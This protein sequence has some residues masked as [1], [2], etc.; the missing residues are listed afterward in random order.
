M[1]IENKKDKQSQEKQVAELRNERY[2][3]MLDDLQTKQDAFYNL[4]IENNRKM[5]E[6]YDS[7]IK[8]LLEAIRQPHILSQE[9]NARMTKID[10]EIDAYLERTLNTCNATRVALI[11]YHNGGNDMLGNSILKMSMSNE[12]C[13]AGIMHVQ[14]SFQNQL[15]SF[16]T[17][18][19]KELNEKGICFIE[20]VENL[21]NIDNSLYQYMKQVGITAKYAIAITN[22]K[23]GSVIG[24]LTIDFANDER[25]NLEQVKRCL[26]DKKLKI[27]ALLN[28]K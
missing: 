2:E 17:L 5:E 24:Y 11:K 7:M 14:H 10:E 19:C 18:L 6:R 12:K 1:E 13:A 22:T 25:I 16:S 4:L 15:R 27:E 20:N 26:N 3:K 8:Q 21:A 9:E 28:L 23:N